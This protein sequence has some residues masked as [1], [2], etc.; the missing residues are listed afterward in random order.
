MK[1]RLDTL[2][3]DLNLCESRQQ[4]Q[5]L[6]RAGSVLVNQQMIDKPGTEVNV[7]A[8]IQVKQRSRFVSRGGEKLAKSLEEFKIEVSDRVCL[9]GG[10]STGGFTDCLLKAGATKVYGVDVGYGQV[11]WGIRND[12]RVVLKE[13]TNLRYLT[14]DQLYGESDTPENYPDFAVVDVSFISLTKILPPL[15]QLLKPNREVVLLVKP[16]FEV[17]RERVG[18][19]GVVRDSKDQARAIFQV[20]SVAISLGWQYRDLTWSPLQGP[21]GN[22]EYLLWLHTVGQPFPSELAIAQITQLAQQSLTQ[23]QSHP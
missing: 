23:S 10:I 4:A 8:K 14:P 19:K 17:G 9:D 13:R 12:P 21:A 20:G 5:G 18:K 7:E 6:I 2:L 1:Q 22:I 15:W 3:V 11:D 16:Q